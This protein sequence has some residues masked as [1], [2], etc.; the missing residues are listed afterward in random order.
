MAQDDSRAAYSGKCPGCNHVVALTIDAPE[1]RKDVAKEIAS[2]INDGL[3]VERTTVGE[4]R[5][6]FDNCICGK[7]QAETLPLFA[8]T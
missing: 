3:I 6:T 2:W 1:Y 8:T 7:Q 4:G 5:N